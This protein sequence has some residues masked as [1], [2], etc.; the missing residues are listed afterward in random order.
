MLV[1]LILSEAELAGNLILPSII[2]FSLA[3]DVLKM[4]SGFQDSFFRRALRA[5]A[6]RFLVPGPQKS[7]MLGLILSAGYTDTPNLGVLSL[8]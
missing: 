2:Q 8:L 6:S 4:T 7:S 3:S 5:N 1:S